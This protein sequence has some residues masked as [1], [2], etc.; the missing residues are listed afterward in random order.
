MNNRLTLVIKNKTKK[1]ITNKINNNKTIT[2]HNRYILNGCWNKQT[3]NKKVFSMKAKISSIRFPTI[4]KKILMFIN[5]IY[6]N[7]KLTLT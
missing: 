4:V 3:L 6:D 5:N 1:Y 2:Q 7:T